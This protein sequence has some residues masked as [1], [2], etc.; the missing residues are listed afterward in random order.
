[1][2]FGEDLDA[3]VLGGAGDALVG[4]VLGDGVRGDGVVVRAVDEERQAL[5]C[6]GVG[7]ERGDAGDDEDGGPR[8]A[9][10]EE[11]GAARGAAGGRALVGLG[12]GAVGRGARIHPRFIQRR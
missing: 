8:G 5:R 3:A 1:M 2:G 12:E 6:G 10:D 4:D 9:G 11:A 7:V